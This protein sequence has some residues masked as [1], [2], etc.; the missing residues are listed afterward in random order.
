MKTNTPPKLNSPIKN[1]LPKMSSERYDK[2]VDTVTSI[3]SGQDN[4][5]ILPVVLF[6]I[7]VRTM[8]ANLKF[9]KFLSI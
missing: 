4:R 7:S 6:R 1:Y 5:S 9:Y 8:L 2:I 3:V